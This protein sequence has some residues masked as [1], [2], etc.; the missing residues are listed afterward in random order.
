[1]ANDMANEYNAL[2]V[3]WNFCAFPIINIICECWGI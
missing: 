3:D 1:M 2:A